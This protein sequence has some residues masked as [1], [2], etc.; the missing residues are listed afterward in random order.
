MAC[1]ECNWFMGECEYEEFGFWQ[2]VGHSFV[3]NTT[4]CEIWGSFDTNLLKS[5]DQ[6]AIRLPA[7]WDI[8]TKGDPFAYQAIN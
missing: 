5:N 4:F 1:Y 8:S 7:A 2:K 3:G 6:I